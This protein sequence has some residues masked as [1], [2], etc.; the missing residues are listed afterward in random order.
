MVGLLDSRA[1]D[2]GFVSATTGTG[3]GL[4]EVVGVAAGV[5]LV[6]GSPRG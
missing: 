5:L 6:A 3:V 4:D 1:G 2:F